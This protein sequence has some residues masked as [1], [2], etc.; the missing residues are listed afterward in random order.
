MENAPD[1]TREPANLRFLRVLVTVLTVV[2]IA[3]LVTIIALFVI[4][5]RTD[6]HAG[7]PALPAG[8]SLPAGAVPEAVTA[9]TGWFAVVTKD[10][11]ILIYGKDGTLLQTVPVTL[12]GGN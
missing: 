3:G 9:G 11:R 12:P 4:R 5:F 7:A 10:S 8:L 2:M 6:M 1:A